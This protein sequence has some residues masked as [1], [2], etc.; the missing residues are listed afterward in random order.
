MPFVPAEN[1]AEVVLNGSW[2]GQNV[3]NVLN[4]VYEI[5]L[6]V[7]ELNSL[8]AS[9]AT[10]WLDNVSLFTS[11]GYVL[12]SVKATDLTTASSPSVE[13]FPPTLYEGDA[14]E[15]SVPN[16]STLTISYST[17]QRGRSYRGRTYMCAIPYSYLS[18]SVDLL[19]TNAA[20]IS[21]AWVGFFD[22]IETARDC[23]HC[24]V[25]RIQEGVTLTEAV[26]TVVTGYF[27]ENNLDSQRRRLEGRGS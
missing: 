9:V 5:T 19:L 2:G 25:S 26:V 13:Y 6:T 8:A 14:D 20:L 15:P 24:I 10:A 27:V 1:T 4:F 23:N 16:N 18:T 21:N 12:T 17:D 7:S 11:I 22:D 3:A